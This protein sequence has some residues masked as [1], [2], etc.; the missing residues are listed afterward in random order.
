VIVL[1]YFDWFGSAEELNEWEKML[2]T[3][4]GKGSGIKYRGTYA[5]DNKKFHFVA[6]FE[7]KSYDKLMECLLDPKNPPRDYKKLTHGMFEIL[8]GPL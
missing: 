2:Q 6:M 7:T 5:P 3:A 4:V 1:F 8:R